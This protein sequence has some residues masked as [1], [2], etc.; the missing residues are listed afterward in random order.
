[1]P[2]T[3]YST[4]FLLTA[5]FAQA[6]A[7]LQ[8]QDQPPPQS[9]L[10]R[11]EHR[12]AATLADQPHWA[13]P[14]VTVNARLEQGFRTDF[15]RQTA[16]TGSTTWNYG[17]AKGLQI[18]PF[19]RI[20]LRFSP[21]PFY[22]HSDPRVIDGFGDTGFRL[23]YRIWASPEERRNAIVT[24]DLNA[25][26]PTG[27]NG[28][29]SC[30]ATV[31]PTLE[32]GKGFGRFAFTTTGG[33][34]LPITGVQKLGRSIVFNNAIQYRATRIVWLETEFNS[35]F[36]RGGKYDGET[37]TFTTPGVI[38]SRIPLNHLPPGTPGSLQI[39]LGLGEQIALTRFHTYDHSPIFTSR[40]RF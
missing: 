7:Q 34:S 20:E 37:Q 30:C 40:L 1:M 31:S 23:K 24:F 8:P 35:T 38:F 27:K 4:L 10:A 21:P 6:H 16:P 9:F 22:T 32:L 36:Y 26:V 14:L 13:T 5:A 28:N 18:V 17:N 3:A 29:G 19:R 25:T 12:V 11:Y 33:G 2:R 39:T 15:I